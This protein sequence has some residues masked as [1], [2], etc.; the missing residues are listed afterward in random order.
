MAMRRVTSDKPCPLGSEDLR[1]PD[2][3]RSSGVHLLAKEDVHLRVN[4]IA[5]G[6]PVADNLTHV[7][8][9]IHSSFSVKCCIDRLNRHRLYEVTLPVPYFQNVLAP[10]AVDPTTT[11]LR[12]VEA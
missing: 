1:R 10:T 7:I 11:S 8:Q 5:R 2:V 12:V 4:R 3:L 6:S 9:R